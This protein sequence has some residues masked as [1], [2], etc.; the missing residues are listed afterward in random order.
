MIHGRSED[1]SHCWSTVSVLCG[2][3]VEDVI[4]DLSC[5][6]VAI[7]RPAL[8]LVEDPISSTS[9]DSGRREIKHNRPRPE[10]LAVRARGGGRGGMAWG[11]A[12][13]PTV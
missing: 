11:H 6:R 8:K 5:W 13:F 2:E 12:H 3:R 7:H 4:F 1:S 10:L 9:F